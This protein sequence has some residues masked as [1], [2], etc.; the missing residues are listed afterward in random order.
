M[1][2]TTD[3]LSLPVAVSVDGTEYVPLVQGTGGSAV[4]RRATAALIAGTAAGFVP[5]TARIN[6]GIGLT[7]GGL[8]T[9]DP[10]LS[11]SIN[12]LTAI[13]AMAIADSFAVNS[14]SDG[15]LVRK[16]TFPNA[17]KAITGLTALAIPDLTADFMVINR[18]ADGLTYK[19]SPS[20]LG[21]ATGNVPAGG[22]T[23]QILAKTS[24]TDYA[25]AWT[26][27]AHELGGLSA[28]SQHDGATLRP[29]RLASKPSERQFL[30]RCCG[31]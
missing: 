11:V 15:N 13:S 16:V 12:E 21:L 2:V 18:A 14:V 6:A 27:G 9:S 25:I 24:D 10:T 7:G 4:T 31:R 20:A 30:M 3:I 8:L 17:M 29:R 5:N 26:T 28:G 1:A 19:I 22:T 23:G